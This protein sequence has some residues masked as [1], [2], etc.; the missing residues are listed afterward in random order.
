MDVDKSE[1]QERQEIYRKLKRKGRRNLILNIITI[2][3][4]IGGIIWAFNF[5]YQYYKYEITN[6]A[7]VEQYV[8][9]IN[10]RVSGY[11][12][13]VYFTEHQYVNE[14]DTL[15]VIDDRE[16]KIKIMNAQ[17]ALMDAEA[18]SDVLKSA[19]SAASSN[20]AASVAN[21]NE[22][23]AKYWKT[24]QDYKRYENL[25]KADAVSKQQF[26]QIK[27]EYDAA[28]AHYESLNQQKSVIE[29]S[30][31]ETLKK[32]KNAEALILQKTADLDL[33]KLNLSYTVITVPYS[34]YVGRRSLEEGQ[35]IQAGQTITNI[36]KN[37]KKWVIANYREKQ[38][39]SIYIGQEVMLKIDAIKNKTFKGHVT[40]IS[41]ATGSKYSLLPTDNSAGNFIKIQQRIPVRIDFDDISD[42]DMSKLRTGMMVTA[43]AISK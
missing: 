37:E 10:A 42:E 15:L 28:K 34:G 9:P 20:V 12:K 35:F 8:S 40:A 26:D 13:K 5:F 4:A 18:S 24:E 11:V 41:D 14:G 33:S 38:I 17:A 16:F 25:L 29:S 7:T 22:A 19:I 3:L 1:L 31:V 43:K 23:K 27:S 36:I 2:L 32:R 6:D 39:E 21:I 30:S